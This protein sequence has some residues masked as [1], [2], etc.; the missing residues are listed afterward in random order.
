MNDHKSDRK[1]VVITGAGKGIGF[2]LVKTFLADQSFLVIATSRDTGQLRQIA[3]PSL[4]IV[5]GDF[6]TAYP[7]IVDEIKKAAPSIHILINNAALVLN[8]SI[9]QVQDKDMDEV[10]E[11]N[12]KTPYKLIRDLMP[13]FHTGSHIL[14]IS[15]MSGFQGSK[16]FKGL[17]LYSASKA[18]LASL[19]ECVAEEWKEEQIYCNCLALGAVDTDMIK[20]SIPGLQSA[21]SAAE[22]AQ[23]IHQFALVGT[24]YYNGQVLPVTLSTY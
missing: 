15:S 10:M 20:I 24:K 19:S 13:R 9:S 16:K 2:E 11:I 17:T 4:K 23:Y 5:T 18:A 12:F 3:N 1:T 8:R 7:S 6:L 21:V 14:N 22:M